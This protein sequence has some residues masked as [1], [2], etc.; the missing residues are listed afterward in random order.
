MS[1]SRNRQLGRVT[2]V[3]AGPGDA[4]LLPLKSF[5]ALA[6]AEFVIADS[7]SVLLAETVATKAEVF[8]AVDEDGI[9]MDHTKRAKQIVESAKAGKR[10]VRLL[11]GDPVLD[12]TFTKE[13]A[14]LEK[15]K[16]AFDFV[17]GISTVSGVAA[18]AGVSLTSKNANEIR[19]V[20]ALNTDVDW[21]EHLDPRVTIVALNAADAAADIAKQLIAAGRAP[22]TPVLITRAGATTAQRSLITTLKETPATVKAAKQTGSGM[23]IIGEPAASRSTLSWFE[24]KPL[25]GWRVLLP[26]TKDHFNPLVA[27]I[28]AL[29][30]SVTRV[31][32]LSVEPPRTPQQMDRAITGLVTGRYEW[33]VFT[34]ANSVKA[35]W[36]KCQEYGLDARAFAGIRLAASGDGTNA[37]LAE[38]GIRADIALRDGATTLQLLEEF[39]VY[40]QMT[41]PINR[42]FLPRADIAT[43]S[44][45]AGLVELGWEV[46][47][48]TAYRTVRAAPPAAEIRDAI[49]AGG[50]D[51][52][53][54]TSSAT[55]RNLVGI[56]GKPHASTLVCAIGPQTSKTCVEHGLNPQVQADDPTPESLL[57]ALTAKG[58]ELR[59]AAVAL[60]ET[61]WRP[62]RRRGSGRRKATT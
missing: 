47:D 42:V 26:T 56:A 17:P 50:F 41:D 13:S 21:S 60:G 6:D 16:V 39:P 1:A 12:G 3:A 55:V 57:L 30:A 23:M 7:D 33:I 24:A 43:E 49:K 18:F 14:I 44:L 53:L 52:V 27:E 20:D 10:V 45:A 58:A 54:F 9:P 25:F 11:S 51:A 5:R 8:T 22:E 46:E 32:T 59:D 2:F 38:Y 15:S 34:C 37:Q 36:E 28:E 61:D 40:D 19:I 31:P 48:I 62:T 29:G 4:D 35:I